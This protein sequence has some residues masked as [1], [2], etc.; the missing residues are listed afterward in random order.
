MS[1][2]KVKVR[3]ERSISQRSKSFA[4]IW[5]FSNMKLQLK[6]SN[7]YEMMHKALSSI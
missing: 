2:Q 1:L 7:G 4:Q 6:F 5:Q 3:G